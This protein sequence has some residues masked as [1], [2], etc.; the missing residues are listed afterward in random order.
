MI[1]FQQMNIGLYL[2]LLPSIVN[3]VSKQKN[4]VD[5]SLSKSSYLK[6]ANSQK[7]QCDNSLSQFNFLEVGIL[8]HLFWYRRNHL[9]D[10]KNDKLG[11]SL[12]ISNVSLK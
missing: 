5:A 6:F 3:I 2:I 10:P 4:N 1:D 9:P 7:I 11:L 8:F 12:M